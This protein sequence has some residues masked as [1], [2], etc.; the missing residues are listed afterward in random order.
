MKEQFQNTW[1]DT[2][3]GPRAVLLYLKEIIDTATR[4]LD[5]PQWVLKHTAARTV[6]DAVA[7]V[8]S[9]ESQLSDANANILWPAL[10]KAIGGKT[11]AGK[12]IVLTALV[13]FAEAGKTF[14]DQDVQANTTLVKVSSICRN[15]QAQFLSDRFAKLS[16]FCRLR[17][18][19]QRDRTPNTANIRLKPLEASLQPE[20][21]WI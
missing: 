10:E 2:V 13:K 7:A 4:H 12:E 5:S 1:N 3:G 15:M 16:R 20:Q 6:A 18:E 21:A 11:W 19:K 17:S 9:A 8:I 14:L